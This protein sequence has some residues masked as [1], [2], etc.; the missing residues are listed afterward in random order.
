[1]YFFCICLRC[2]SLGT[3]LRNEGTVLPLRRFY[4]ICNAMYRRKVGVSVNFKKNF[5]NFAGGVVK[6]PPTDCQV[7]GNSGNRVD[8]LP[9]KSGGKRVGRPTKEKEDWILDVPGFV[10][11]STPRPSGILIFPVF[12]KPSVSGLTTYAETSRRG[13][14]GCIKFR[15]Q[16]PAGF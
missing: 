7:M 15:G 14:R 8:N 10:L 9:G 12:G 6:F 1:M 5:P 11:R 16:M 3:F 13:L 4:R 2:G